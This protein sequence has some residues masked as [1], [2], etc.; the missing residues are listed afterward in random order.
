MALEER[1]LRLEGSGPPAQ[2]FDDAQRKLSDAV[3]IVVET[4][5]GQERGVRIRCPRTLGRARR[6]AA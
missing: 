6:M 3:R 4:P 5:L 2:R 1:C